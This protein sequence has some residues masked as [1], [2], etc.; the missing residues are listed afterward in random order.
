MRRITWAYAAWVLVAGASGQSV[1][2]GTANT[3]ELAERQQLTKQDFEAMTG[4]MLKLAEELSETDP[5][6]AEI[7]RE[8]VSRARG[9]YQISEDMDKVVR[10]LR[11]GMTELAS[12]AEGDVID[13]L[14]RLLRL[15]REGVTS[16]D[17]RKER[18]ARWK[19][20]RERIEALIETESRMEHVTDLHKR[21][22][23]IGR[24]LGKLDAQ[25]AAL[26]AAQK[27]LRTEAG[28]LP[29][30]DPAARKLAELRDRLGEMIERQEALTG[31]AR[32]AAAR[33]L[34]L[35]G[36]KQQALGE[37]ADEFAAEMV[38][39][40]ED[41]DVRKAVGKDGEAQKGLEEAT[42]K[43]ASAGGKMHQAAKALHAADA[44]GA[45]EPQQGAAEDFKAA[46]AALSRA[47]RIAAEGTPAGKLADTQDDLS[48]KAREA[49]EA[50][51]KAG[52]A[53]R[54]ADPPD[55][56]GAAEE[57]DRAS[58]KLAGQ[59][60]AGAAEH[61]D[62]ALKRLQAE[63]KR[64]AELHRRVKEA[65]SK[66][67]PEQQPQQADLARRA[68]A[69]AEEMNSGESPDPGQK[70]MQGASGSMSK[71]AGQLGKSNA[72][73]ANSS[74]KDALEQMRKAREA[75]DEAIAQEQQMMQAEAL[76]RID[77]MLEV[78]LSKQRGVSEKTGATYARRGKDGYS[79][80]DQVTL[81]ELGDR[82][83]ALTGEIEQIEKMLAE[84]GSTVVFPR[85]LQQVRMDM[86]EAGRRLGE[87]RAGPMTQEIQTGV[88]QALRQL[89]DAMRKELAERRKK[90][91]SGGAA[92]GGGG[93]KKPPL[94][95]P[96]AEL[97][98]LRSLQI[99]I[100]RRTGVVAEQAG[101]DEMPPDNVAEAHRNLADRQA[102]VED[103]T[104]KVAEQMNKG[105]GTDQE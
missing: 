60:A 43:T 44:Q 85:I 94:V 88:E 103:M 105:A 70:Q 80:P 22:A 68:K 39:A 33:E 53:A 96:L 19:K 83:R 35:T 62:E 46:H 49:S 69:T 15:L 21:S 56:A 101:S 40:A 66:K 97:K 34:P 38:D 6:S 89:I 2:E 23:E 41:P 17:R 78:V 93:G 98:L 82:Q 3:T 36:R 1:D 32:S 55:L 76:A 91:Q 11:N 5:D 65:Q 104:R 42:A 86:D 48:G 61:Q 84:E 14:K 102:N 31:D 57:M 54:D 47:A 63:R 37:A 27:K 67:L 45:A 64:L 92:G 10:H 59:D 58:R 81:G 26:I 9:A 79:R 30:A 18:I 71:A 95:P 87:R 73:G 51:A 16:T 12:R 29:A 24:R 77:R 20:L 4:E 100:N 7:L 99:Q 72:G 52:E 13:K 74:Q 75:L 50:A 28:E 90:Q 8:A 25:I